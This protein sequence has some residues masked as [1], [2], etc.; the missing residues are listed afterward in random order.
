MYFNH[1]LPLQILLD[2]LPTYPTLI[3]TQ[4]NKQKPNTTKPPPK[5]RK[6]NKST[7]QKGKKITK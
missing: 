7:A 3:L 1:I 2:P 6:Q 5:P 4:K